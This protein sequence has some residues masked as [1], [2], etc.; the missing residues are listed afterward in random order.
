LTWEDKVHSFRPFSFGPTIKR[1]GMTFAHRPLLLSVI[2]T[3]P[4]CLPVCNVFAQ[5]NG[6]GILD[7][8]R[9]VDSLDT[10]GSRS[11]LRD[12]E[13]EVRSQLEEENRFAPPSAGDTDIGEQLILKEAIRQRPFRVLVDV[14]IFSTDNVGN[15]PSSGEQSDS[16]LVSSLQAGW[17]PR[18][19]GLWFADVEISQSVY[20]Y[21]I[22]DVLDFEVFEA[23]ANFARI[24]PRFGNIVV[25]AGP[26]FQYITNN[27]F[28]DELLTSSSI[29]GGVQKIVLLDR[30]NSIHIGATVDWGLSSN[31]DEVFRR[32]VTAEAAWR[33]KIM[34]D[35]IFTPSV[36]Y[37]YYDYTRVPR[38]DEMAVAEL[39]VTWMPTR[40]MEVAVSGSHISN[41]SNL[42]L[43]DFDTNTFGA[44]LG[45]K[46]RF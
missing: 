43:F 1:Y 16:F 6:S 28:Q 33:F 3:L 12:T 44:S 2:L 37:T 18:L 19:A 39:N 17:Q 27:S 46:L 4:V 7:P 9:R 20:R 15:T 25:Y 24:F 14:N 23:G 11:S 21:D 26:Q 31:V 45:V 8:S 22:F 42:E 13:E 34:R 36:R 30:R 5:V 40:W 32:E 10:P 29:E 38:D 35:L 41:D